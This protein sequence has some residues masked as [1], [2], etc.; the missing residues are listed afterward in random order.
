MERAYR[1]QTSA[2][3]IEA[4]HGVVIGEGLPDK[5]YFAAPP[6]FEGEA[7]KWTPEHLLLAAV[8]SCFTSTFHAFAE[9]AKLDLPALS[10]D[11][12][13]ILVKEHGGFRF[14]QIFL[15][16][17]VTVA[18]EADREQAQRLLQKAARAC[19]VARSLNS[20]V[21]LEPTVAVAAAACA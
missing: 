5:I 14:A 7:D 20:K 1:Y 4:R 8:P 6:E 3:W 10:A 15:R 19:F 17:A 21:V 2:H 18:R 11:C 13:G 9:F 16:P 12:E